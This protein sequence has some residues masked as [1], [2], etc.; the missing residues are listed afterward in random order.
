MSLHI[1]SRRTVLGAVGAITT[2]VGWNVT[3]ASWAWAG[4]TARLPGVRVVSVP[5]LDGTLTTD[6][7]QFGSYAHD[8]SRLVTGTVPWAVLTPGSVQDIAKM[9]RYARSNNLKL[10][11]NG[12]SGTG[13]DLESHS[14]YGQAAVP[15]GIPVSA[16]GMARIL[17]TGADTVTVEAGVTF[18]EITD[19]LLSRGRTLPALPDYLPLSV[20]GTLGVGG[21]GLTMAPRV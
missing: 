14:C 11:V 19:H 1:S 12:R 5:E 6:T 2:V 8:F 10:A 18:A 7:S 16:R 20:G 13:G 17:S 9:T 15:G 4:D 21:I 3:A